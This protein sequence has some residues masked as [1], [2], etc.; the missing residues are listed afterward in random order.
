MFDAQSVLSTSVM[1]PDP[2]WPQLP[3]ARSA[4]CS[5]VWSDLRLQEQCTL[6]L[7]IYLCFYIYLG[8]CCAGTAVAVLPGLACAEP[9]GGAC[10]VVT[11]GGLARCGG[12]SLQHTARVWS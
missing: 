1:Y 6:S 11:L 5:A 10:S 4:H 9:A 2:K 12:R 3:A 8:R 7:Y